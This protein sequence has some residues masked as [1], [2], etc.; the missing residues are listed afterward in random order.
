MFL[1]SVARQTGIPANDNRAGWWI[2]DEWP[3]SHHLNPLPPGNA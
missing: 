2:G 3:D 1:A